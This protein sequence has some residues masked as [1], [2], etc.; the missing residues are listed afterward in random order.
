MLQNTI[1]PAIFP[2][3]YE[4]KFLNTIALISSGRGRLHFCN[5]LFR[6]G[7]C[8]LLSKL[9]L[10]VIL[11]IWA[12]GRFLSDCFLRWNWTDC[13]VFE[14]KALVS[15]SSQGDLEPGLM[16]LYPAEF[17]P[18]TRRESLKRAEK[19]SLMPREKV[20][21]RFSSS[22]WGSAESFG[23]PSLLRYTSSSELAESWFRMLR[24]E[25]RWCEW[26]ELGDW[27]IVARGCGWCACGWCGEDEWWTKGAEMGGETSERRDWERET[28]DAWRRLWRRSDGR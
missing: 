6:F 24:F 16:C 13:G 3:Q 15:G 25:M 18:C 10:G 26:S 8:T 19:R 21:V 1:F 12:L 22:G 11:R 17:F 14:V 2:S 20:P 7:E 23:I 9:F 28:R 5:E 27:C 4:R